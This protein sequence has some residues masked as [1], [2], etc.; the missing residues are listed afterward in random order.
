VRS[1]RLSGAEWIHPPASRL[2]W[3]HSRR[4]PYLSVAGSLTDPSLIFDYCRT[5]ERARF[6]L[7]VLIVDAHDDAGES[8]AQ[9]VR[10]WGH[11]VLSASSGTEALQIGLTEPVDVVLLELSFPE[12]DGY[13]LVRRFRDQTAGKKCPLFVAV[14]TKG[15]DGDR[16]RSADEGINLHLL[17]PIDPAVLCG[18]LERF[19]EF[20]R[21]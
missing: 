20:L 9:L 11:S 21:K 6:P 8:M 15:R 2:E 12:Y 17:K 4:D 16:Q 7:K 1:N 19:A 18:V 10:L 13:E 14:T 3:I 5:M